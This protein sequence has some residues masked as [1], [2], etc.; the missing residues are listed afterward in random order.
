ME[1]LYQQRHTQVHE[2]QSHMGR[3]KMAGRQS[4]HLVE[5][6]IQASIDQI[7]GHPERL[8]SSK[9]TPNKRQNAKLRVD[10][11]KYDVQHLQTALRNFQHRR[12]A[13]EQQ[14]RQREELLSRTFTTNDSDTTIPMDESL[15]FNSSLQNIHHGM[16]DLFG[17]GHSILEGLR[18][19]RLTLKGTQKKILDIAKMLGLSNTVMRLIEKRDFQDKYFMI[20]GMLLTCAVMF[21]VVQY[22]T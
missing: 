3:L 10:Q 15:Q 14:E 11:L 22:L 6:E 1:P 5:N 13:R 8:A 7:F 16:N 4:V 21:L 19:Q 18:A 9:E 17:G 12:Y 2:I 20:G